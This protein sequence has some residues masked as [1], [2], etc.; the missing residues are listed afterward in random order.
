[1]IR[2]LKDLRL[3]RK[4]V[5]LIE[6]SL[7]AGLISVVA[8]GILGAVGGKIKGIFTTINTSLASA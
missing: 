3:D 7:I 1:M 2:L 6:Y 5:T 8:I 4:G